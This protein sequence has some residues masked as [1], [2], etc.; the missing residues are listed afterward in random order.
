MDVRDLECFLAVAEEGTISRAAER[1]HMTQPPLTVRVRALERELG[2]ELLVRHGRGVTVTAAGR[3]L[4]D[5]ARRLLADLTATTETVR[6][7]GLGTRG[8]L[9]LAIGHSV[10]PR[11]LSRL[12]RSVGSDVDLALV[13]VS[14]AEVLDRVHHREAHAGLLSQSR[15]SPRRAAGL[16]VA[17]VSRAPLVVVLPQAHPCADAERVDLAELPDDRVVVPD[18]AEFTP[19]EFTPTGGTRHRAESVSHALALVQAGMGV[20]LLT[21]EHVPQVWPGLL[22]RPLRQHT[23]IVESAVCWRPD[24]HSPV[25]RRFLRAALSTPEPDVLGQR[26]ARD[27][28]ADS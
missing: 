27:R 16:E 8:R 20:V 23:E 13:E 1:L 5:H 14:D 25:M 22:A 6:A 15:S 7:V 4:A 17:V 9:A 26:F 19:T 24:E 18:I 2:V 11:L 28:P 12:L 3:L 10:A 21:T